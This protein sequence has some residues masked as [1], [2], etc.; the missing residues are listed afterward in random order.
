[1]RKRRLP[2]QADGLGG[3]EIGSRQNLPF[4]GGFGAFYQVFEDGTFDAV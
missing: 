1:L 2:F 4:F 3:S